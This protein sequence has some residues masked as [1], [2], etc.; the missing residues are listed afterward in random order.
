M[1][2]FKMRR[3]FGSDELHSPCRFDTCSAGEEDGQR[4]TAT[5]VAPTTRF[6][7]VKTN[8]FQ[9]REREFQ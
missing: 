2:H 5:A 1:A 8:P 6:Q 9:E 4:G 7:F 3:R